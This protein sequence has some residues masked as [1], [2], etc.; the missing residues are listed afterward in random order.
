M[1]RD[2]TF[3]KATRQKKAH[4]REGWTKFGKGRRVSLLNRVDKEPSVNYALP[5]QTSTA[6]SRNRYTKTMC[7]R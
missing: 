3:S 5:Q 6:P 7:Q 1:R 2:H 4:A